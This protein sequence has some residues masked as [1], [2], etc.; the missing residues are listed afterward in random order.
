MCQNKSITKHNF[1]FVSSVCFLFFKHMR[2]R[3]YYPVKSLCMLHLGFIGFISYYIHNTKSSSW[4]YRN[5][6]YFSFLSIWNSCFKGSLFSK[7]PTFSF[8]VAFSTQIFQCLKTRLHIVFTII[9]FY[10][11]IILR[12]LYF[13]DHTRIILEE[14]TMPCLI[15]LHLVIVPT[16]HLP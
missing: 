11:F 15:P 2:T 7:K 3:N 14:K 4:S 10:I 5:V 8:I 12:N 1:K 16:T 9:Q 13:Q 6:V